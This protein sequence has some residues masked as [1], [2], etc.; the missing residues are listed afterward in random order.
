MLNSQELSDVLR[1]NGF[2]VTPQRLAVYEALAAMK[3]HPNA[4]MLYSV[5]QPKYPSMSFA[6]V[7][8]TVEILHKINVIQILNTENGVARGDVVFGFVNT[9]K[10]KAHNNVVF[11]FFAGVQSAGNKHTPFLGA[12]N[13][14]NGNSVYTL[15]SSCIR[16]RT[17]KGFV[18]IADIQVYNIYGFQSFRIKN[19][20]FK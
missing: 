8:K 20:Y 6:T 7:Y 9:V 11:V 17:L 10:S 15:K 13:F 16:V 4:E 1:A 3:T 14:A 18:I 12:G 19:V 5:L 2:K